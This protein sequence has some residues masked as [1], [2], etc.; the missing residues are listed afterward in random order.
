MFR[1][2]SLLGLALSAL[3]ALPL[4]VASAQTGQMRGT[5]QLMGADGKPAPVAGALIDVYRTDITGRDHTKSDK[6]GEWVFAGL[7]FVGTYIVAASAPGA[8][9]NA[10]AGVRVVTEAPVD[11]ILSPGDG[12]RLNAEE[13]KKVAAGGPGPAG[14]GGG[15][16]SA[17]DKAKAAELAKK[18]AEIIEKNKKIEES[19]TIVTRTLKA[20]NEA[21]T[22]KNYDEA[23][24]QY[25]EGINA[26]PE[27]PG[28]PV[29]L[30]NKAVALRIRGVDRYNNALKAA[31]DSKKA[32]FDAA[33]KDWHDSADSANAAL[34][35][36]NEQAK[37][38]DQA[39][40]TASVG[41][42]YNALV[43]RKEA[44][45]FVATKPADPS[46]ADALSAAYEEYIA[47]ES[48]AAK[49]EKARLELAQFLL[50]SGA[51]DKALAAFQK[52]LAD[53][54]DDPDANLGAGLAL[55]S[56]GDK[57]KYQEAANYL[58][59]FVDKAPDTHKEKEGI[60]AVL[61]ELKNTENVVPEKIT[62]NKRKRP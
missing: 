12:R 19:N 21:L 45:R 35:I 8:Q 22:A 62:P 39:L 38:T 53:K 11:I 55:Y 25:D 23:I 34:K 54:P 10:R 18:N 58:Q 31:D 36:V 6:K 32:G 29:L 59:H 27:H 57:G 24:K 9:P 15:G 52:I 50:E 17:E 41:I 40:A 4:T 3:V 47:V 46:Q 20:G 2:Y 7:P 43:A 44:M 16:S 14:G 42:K 37:S 5:V 48:D 30:T 61:A 1:K 13:A 28:A 49:K 60:K 26:D 51:G 33:S 56:T